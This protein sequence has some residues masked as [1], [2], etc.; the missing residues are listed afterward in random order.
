[1]SEI[2]GGTPIGQEIRLKNKKEDATNQPAIGLTI[3][4]HLLAM[5]LYGNYRVAL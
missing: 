2:E 3:E 4:F 5:D 1:M